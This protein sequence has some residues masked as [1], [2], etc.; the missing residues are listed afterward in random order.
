MWAR[1]DDMTVVDMLQRIV[2][3]PP[4][5]SLPAEVLDF[6]DGVDTL[7][8]LRYWNIYIYQASELGDWGAEPPKGADTNILGTRMVLVVG[9]KYV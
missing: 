2:R 5:F 4:I 9:G 8:Y 6:I 3:Y 7:N 1:H